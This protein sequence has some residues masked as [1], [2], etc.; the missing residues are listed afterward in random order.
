MPDTQEPSSPLAVL[1]DADNARPTV[2]E[3]L[4]AEVAKFGIANVSDFARL[5]SRIVRDDAPERHDRARRSVLRRD[6]DRDGRC[7]S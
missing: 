7:A 2:I 1:I 4:L 5:T 3:P 6:D